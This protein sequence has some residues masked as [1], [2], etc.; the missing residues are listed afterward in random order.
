MSDFENPAVHVIV[1]DSVVTDDV[2]AVE[3]NVWINESEY[4]IGKGTSRRDPEDKVDHETGYKIALGR[5][6]REVGRGILREGNERVKDADA[7]KKQQ[8]QATEAAKARKRNRP[9]YA[10]AERASA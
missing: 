4:Y 6:I 10:L 2:A 3:V 8:Q 9:V 5:A 7:F 1:T